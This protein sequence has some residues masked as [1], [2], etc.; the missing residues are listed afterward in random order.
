MQDVF[1]TIKDWESQGLMI[2]LATVMKTWGSSP[3]ASGSNMVINARGE[4]AGSVSGG[5]VE[6]AVVQEALALF[7][8]GAP[9]LLHFGVAD[10]TAWE[11]GLACGGEID[12][13]VQRL[14]APH[15]AWGAELFSEIE[16]ALTS[17]QSVA[18]ATIFE[19]PEDFLGLKSVMRSHGMRRSTL[20]NALQFLLDPHLQTAIREGNPLLR[21]IQYE[22]QRLEVFIDVHVP[23]TTL[24]II[25]A[26][27]IA[28]VLTSLAKQLGFRVIVIDPRG[29]FATRQRFPDADEVLQ[30]WPVEGMEK[31]G[32]DCATA[33]AVLSHDPKLDDP[34]LCAALPSEAFYVGALGSR[35]TQAARRERLGAEGIEPA[36]LDRLRGPIG[37]DLGGRHPA[38]IALGILA[39]I[40]AVRHG[41]SL[42]QS[43]P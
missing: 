34:A 8:G 10:E 22:G 38:E 20:P 26:V 5:C 28:V 16:H 37:L 24:L 17:R 27:H 1:S 18:L 21:T 15:L 13:L 30:V 3:R 43:H 9:K 42:V 6:G 35:K 11:V 41:T 31:V 14:P 39:E 23:G 4:M 40:I 32:I 12:I 33:V 7:P 19:G 36:T 25:G 2:A 29:A